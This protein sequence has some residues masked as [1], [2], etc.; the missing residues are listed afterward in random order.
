MKLLIS[1]ASGFLGR[2]LLLATPADWRVTALWNRSEDFPRFV[3]SRGLRHVVPVRVDLTAAEPEAI[4]ATAGDAFDAAVFLAANGDPAVSVKRPRFDLASNALALVGILERVRIGRALYFSSGA[5][6]DGLRGDVHPGVA[7]RPRLPYAIS[8]LAAEH[9]L[10]S[11]TL[12]GRVGSS[13]AVRFFGAYGPWEPERKIYT[14]LVRAFALE[15]RADITLRGDGRNLID[16]MFVQD[17]VDGLLRLLGDRSPR[18]PFEVVDFASGAPTSVEDLT[19]TAAAA[20]GI[21][22]RIAHE[23]EV[24]EYIEFRSTD[25]TMRDRYGF[26]PRVALADGL[27]RLAEHLAASGAGA[28]PVGGAR[29]S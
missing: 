12:A 5:V 16:A 14:R 23:G 21:E 20:F 9:Y 25:A 28:G 3:E 17:A 6:Y 27:R 18:E 7:V 4:A 15:R 10:R 22:P 11:F 2:N 1:G 8:K 29:R 13:A 19:R 26:R 24:P